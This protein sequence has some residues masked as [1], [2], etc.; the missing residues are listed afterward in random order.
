MLE[1]ILIVLYSLLVYVHEKPI[2]YSI[3]FYFDHFKKLSLKRNI[4]QSLI[5][6]RHF[7]IITIVM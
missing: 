2:K 6:S 5:F 7:E 4:Q 1:D 3:S